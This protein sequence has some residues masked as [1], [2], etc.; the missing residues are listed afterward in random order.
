MNAPFEYLVATLEALWYA[1]EPPFTGR[2]RKLSRAKANA[3]TRMTGFSETGVRN[4][5]SRQELLRN[6]SDHLD[7]ANIQDDVLQKIKADTRLTGQRRA[8]VIEHL[9][10]Q[11]HPLDEVS[12]HLILSGH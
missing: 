1:Q 3:S 5:Q 7:I 8:Q 6:I 4:R 11:I 9:D 2:N 10:G 12:Y